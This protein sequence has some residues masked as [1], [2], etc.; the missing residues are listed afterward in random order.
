[1]PR[2]WWHEIEMLPGRNVAAVMQLNFPEPPS[3]DAL[4]SASKESLFSADL[5]SYAEAFRGTAAAPSIA[6][7]P[8]RDLPSSMRACIAGVEAAGT[9]AID[10]NAMFQAAL[11]AA[12]EDWQAELD[13]TTT[14]A[15]VRTV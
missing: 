5:V 4:T 14:A 8:L 9:S 10:I 1:M 2:R 13:E 3:V 15:F 11:D 6:R 12:D 7:V